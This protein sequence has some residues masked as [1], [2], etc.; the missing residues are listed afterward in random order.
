MSS[1]SHHVVPDPNG[2]WNVR[3][4]GSDRISGHYN[5]QE[6][7]INDGRKISINQHSELF[8]HGR[9][10]QFR[11]RDSHGNDKCPPRG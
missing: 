11:E 3:K 5:T 6:Q 1:K 2:G 10:G 7:A 8:I 9:N 4:G